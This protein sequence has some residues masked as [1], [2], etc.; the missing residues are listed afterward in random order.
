MFSELDCLVQLSLA[1][2]GEKAA[3]VASTV[4][5]EKIFIR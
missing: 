5:H 4:A 2:T 3:A 1:V